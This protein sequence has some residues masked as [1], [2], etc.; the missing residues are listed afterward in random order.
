MESIVTYSSKDFKVKKVSYRGH[1]AVVRSQSDVEEAISHIK[2]KNKLIDVMPFAIRM[3]SIC[4]DG[5]TEEMMEHYEDDGDWGAG[6]ILL[7]CLKSRKRTGIFL[8]VTRHVGGCFPSE[9][10][11]MIKPTMVKDAANAAIEL[12]NDSHTSV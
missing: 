5:E 4:D 11:Q 7:E 1:I 8:A 2:R 9:L 6:S 12:L 10:V 3:S